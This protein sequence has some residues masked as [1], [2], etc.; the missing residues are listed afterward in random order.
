MKKN[1]IIIT[2][3]FLFFIKNVPAQWEIGLI[4]GLN[5]SGLSGDKPDNASY[6]TLI[7]PAFGVLIETRLTS[8]VR[9]GLQPQYLQRGSKI[10]YK[11]SREQTKK[12]S[13]SIFLRIGYNAQTDFI[14][15]LETSMDFLPQSD[16]DK[17]LQAGLTTIN[18]R[19]YFQ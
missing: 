4:G 14:I 12:N 13:Q 8:D 18:L 2:L 6:R 7:T 16:T 11:V 17:T 3:F 1:S 10:A 5:R 15:S 19:Y 9:I